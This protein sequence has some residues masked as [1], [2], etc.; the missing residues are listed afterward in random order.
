MKCLY[1]REDTRLSKHI[2]ELIKKELP[3]SDSYILPRE[4]RHE[5][6]NVLRERQRKEIAE[7]LVQRDFDFVFSVGYFH[8]LSSF[9]QMIGCIYISWI[10]ELPNLDMF[11]NSITNKCNCIFVAD[12]FWVDWLKQRGV[13]QAYFMPAAAYKA[14]RSLN[15]AEYEV[16]F[17][18][19]YPKMK[20]TSPFY[21]LLKV[22]LPCKG[23][24]DGLVHTQRVIHGREIVSNSIIPQVRE[25]L[26]KYDPIRVPPDVILNIDEIYTWFEIF[27]QV[28]RQEQELFFRDFPGTVSVFNGQQAEEKIKYP[29]YP[30]PKDE[31]IGDIIASTDINMHLPNR[32][33]IHGMD[34]LFFEILSRGGFMITPKIKDMEEYFEDEKDLFVL[35]RVTGI[36]DIMDKIKKDYDYDKKDALGDRVYQ[37]IKE[38]H[39]YDIRIKQLIKMI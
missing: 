10:V 32:Y 39:T 38:G 19:W 37:K 20:T 14:E 24:L 17:I 35:D 31:E 11:R 12:S 8:E 22:S 18:G 29:V 2:E 27:P 1:F 16:S 3:D 6:F 36:R 9:C 33:Y 13:E 23:Y 21:Q 34:P 28:I 5:S 25:E 7:R 26:L 30:Y 15:F 4:V